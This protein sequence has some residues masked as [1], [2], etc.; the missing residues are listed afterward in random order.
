MAGWRWRKRVGVEEEGGDRG[1]WWSK[2]RA[3]DSSNAASLTFNSSNFRVNGHKSQQNTAL[4]GYLMGFQ[5]SA[6]VPFLH[7]DVI[8]VDRIRQIPYP[9][10]KLLPFI[11]SDDDGIVDVFH[12]AGSEVQRLLRPR[13]LPDQRRIADL[14]FPVL[15][16]AQRALF[17]P[18]AHL[19]RRMAR[20]ILRKPI[21]I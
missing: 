7:F 21:Q 4:A 3:Q 2:E 12:D 5:E 19:R 6:V 8:V 1:R 13:R 9:P 14:H 11:E 20:K 10:L 15:L 18:F 16:P 17:L